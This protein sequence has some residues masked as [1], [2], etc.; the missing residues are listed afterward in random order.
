MWASLMTFLQGIWD[1]NDGWWGVLGMAGNV[2]FF[3]R[4]I[5]QWLASERAK[6]SVVPFVFW[7]LSIVGTLM[8]LVYSI[9][10]NKI[11]FMLG[12][13]L[14]LIPYVRNIMLIRRHEAVMAAKAAG[15]QDSLP[16]T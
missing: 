7:P 6:R 1:K 4:F 3:L 16:P 11:V 2:F 8:I 5:V 12:Y 10:L 14:N 13:S 15:G 9:H